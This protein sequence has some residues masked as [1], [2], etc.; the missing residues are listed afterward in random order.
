MLIQIVAASLNKE[1]TIM[2]IDREKVEKVLSEYGF[3]L[4]RI[5]GSKRHR[6][7]VAEQDWIYLI[8][9]FHQPERAEDMETVHHCFMHEK[10]NMKGKKYEQIHVKDG[11]VFQHC[12]KIDDLN[13]TPKAVYDHLNNEFKVV[14]R[15][16]DKKRYATISKPANISNIKWSDQDRGCK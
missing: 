13:K 2:D 1:G 14:I 6:I 5:V 3:T 10:K 7:P 9:H 16:I 15:E 12:L 11:K 8:H 4:E